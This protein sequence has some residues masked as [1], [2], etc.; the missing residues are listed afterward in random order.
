MSK[1]ILVHDAENEA[2]PVIINSGNILFVKESDT[3]TGAS[4]IELNNVDEDT[5]ECSFNV[6]ETREQ[7]FEM[8]K[9]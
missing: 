8:L 7:I 9:S 3:L 6:T 2:S 1:F 5:T 4:Y